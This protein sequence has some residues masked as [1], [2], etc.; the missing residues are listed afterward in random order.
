[1]GGPHYNV[2]ERDKSYCLSNFMVRE[3]LRTKYLTMAKEN[4][5]IVLIGDVGKTV[6]AE[7]KKFCCD[8][9]KSMI[10]CD[11]P[12][13]IKYMHVTIKLPSV[14]NYHFVL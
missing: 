6:H 12:L 7:V 13:S 3:Y 9:A 8:R 2:M 1:M 10:I 11:Y 5:S 4:S 14:Y